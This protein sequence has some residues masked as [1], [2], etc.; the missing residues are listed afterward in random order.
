KTADVSTEQFTSDNL[1][2]DQVDKLTHQLTDELTGLQDDKTKIKS[3][4]VDSSTQ[5]KTADVSTE[6]FTSDNLTTDQVDRLTHQLTDELTGLQDDKTRIK[7]VFSDSSTPQETA[8]VSTEQFT[9]DNLT[10]AQVDRL[11]H[12]LTDIFS[13]QL[14]AQDKQIEEK[15]RQLSEKDLQLAEK[16]KQIALLMEQTNNLT[17]ALQAAQA[18]AAADKQQL[19]L[20]AGK[21]NE[22][23]ENTQK[24]ETAK[25]SF[26]SR[27]FRK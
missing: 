10:T 26:F 19:L 1:T 17:Q 2:T 6:Q 12:Q 7:S 13:A 3:A 11:T 8:D 21:Q 15:D 23:L 5:Q 9:S 27:I 24:Q 14:T 4:F 20:Q 18:L 16:D 22:Q 25:K